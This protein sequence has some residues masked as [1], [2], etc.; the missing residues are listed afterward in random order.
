M[1]QSTTPLLAWLKLGGASDH[2]PQ[3]RPQ[4]ALAHHREVTARLRQ[5]AR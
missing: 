3:S 4:T 2:R 5:T 1:E